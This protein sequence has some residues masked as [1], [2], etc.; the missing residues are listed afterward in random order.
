MVG[1]G[2][3]ATRCAGE[4][5]DLANGD[6]D[7]KMTLKRVDIDFSLT[8]VEIAGRV[9]NEFCAHALESLPE[10]CCGLLAGNSIV[11]FRSVHRCRNEMTKMHQQ[12]SLNFPRD[13]REAF[14]M[15]ELDYCRAQETAATLGEVITAVYHSHVGYGAYFSEMDQEFAMNELFPFPGVDHIVVS[16]MERKVGQIGLFSWDANS[17]LYV[18]R[19]VVPSMT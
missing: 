10:E 7:S 15:N 19:A 5:S 17:R 11:R 16:T 14:Y 8:P 12:D 4:K 9:V 18:G 2:F 3:T 1:A 6:E 13:G